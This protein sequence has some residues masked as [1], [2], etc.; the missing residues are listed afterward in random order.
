MR[1]FHVSTDLPDP[2]DASEEEELVDALFEDEL[3]EG[4]LDEELD[5]PILEE[6]LELVEATLASRLD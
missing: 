2:N 6:A 5:E 3:L 4:C 1:P